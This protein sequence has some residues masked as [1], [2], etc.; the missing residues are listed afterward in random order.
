MKV[1]CWFIK[2][3]DDQKSRPILKTVIDRVVL[4]HQRGRAFGAPML[5][6]I[7]SNFKLYI[8]TSIDLQ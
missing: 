5:D 4:V 3:Y 7:Y 2:V 6:L 1:I 8:L